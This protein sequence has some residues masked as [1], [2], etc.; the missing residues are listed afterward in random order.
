MLK[1][2]S[3]SYCSTT[4]FIRKFL[5]N[6]RLL[7]SAF[8]LFYLYIG[9]NNNFTSKHYNLLEVLKTV[10][11]SNKLESFDIRHK[12]QILKRTKN[13]KIDLEEKIAQKMYK[14]LRCE[15]LQI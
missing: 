2:K 12:K 8:G 15:I 6:F 7:N 4:F 9:I 11:G 1:K 10:L 14:N 3:F 13:E 5:A